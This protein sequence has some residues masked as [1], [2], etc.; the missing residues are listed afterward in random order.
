MAGG[1]TGLISSVDETTAVAFVS[2]LSCTVIPV[3]ASGSEDSTD[4]SVSVRMRS[5]VIILISFYIFCSLDLH[6]VGRLDSTCNR[7]SMF[8]DRRSV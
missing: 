6:F 1:A 8:I 2:T 7:H 4:V 5:E 3:E